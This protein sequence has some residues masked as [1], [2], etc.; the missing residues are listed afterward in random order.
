[1]DLEEA[2]QVVGEFGPYQQRAVAV[3]VL[4]Q[5]CALKQIYIYMWKQ[6]AVAETVPAT[7]AGEIALRGF[8]RGLLKPL[9]IDQENT[10]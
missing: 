3:L 7:T 8:T 9:H 1:M 4:T 2:F 10:I 5:V 6:A